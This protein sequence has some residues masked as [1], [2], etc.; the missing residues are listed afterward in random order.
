MIKK[1]KD[2]QMRLAFGLVMLITG[3]AVFTGCNDGSEVGTALVTD[4]VTIVVDSSF[5]LTGRTLRSDAVI[6]RTVMQILGVIDVEEF[7]YMTSDI[8]TQFMPTNLFDTNYVTVNDI[9]SL[10]LVMLV[11]KT[12]FTGDSM[13]LMGLEVYPLTRQLEAP[14]YSDF[15]PAGYYDPT[16]IGSTVY[17][18]TKEAEP[19]SLQKNE[20]MTVGVRLPL[21]MGRKFYSEYLRDPATFGSPT[22]FAK[23]FPGLYIK[24]SY[25]SGRITRV[26]NTRMQM[27]YHRHYVNDKGNDT[28]TYGIGNYFAVTPEI[29]TNNNLHLTLSENVEQRIAEGQSLIIAPVGLEVELTF[30]AAEVIASYKAG[31]THSA[32][33]LNSLALN[34]PYENISNKY[35][36]SEPEN[37]LLVLKKDR[38]DFFRNNKLPDDITSFRATPTTLVDGTT[39]YVFPDMRQYLLN[40]MKK[41]EITPDDY[42]FVLVPVSV[43]T[44]TPDSYYGSVEPT[45][46]AVTPYVSEPR[47][48]RILPEKS[49]I[50][51][52]YS[53]QTTKY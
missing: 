35:D 34:V 25:G 23:F 10:V 19:D 51:F 37:V 49:K 21:E 42:T 2:M 14:M 47:M 7:G 50:Y 39:A 36:I 26:A 11:N 15:D 5:T 4:E 48:T 3:A 17:N 43:T 9:D 20:Y 22:N 38:E 52:V 45:L 40:L 1:L 6:S 32:G 46:T 27:Y 31:T 53:K 12:G 33:I 41:D 28:T 8:V 13:A 16:P 24:N 18:L 30:P 44:E 29:I